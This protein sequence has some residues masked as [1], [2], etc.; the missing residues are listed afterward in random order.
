MDHQKHYETRARQVW[1]WHDHARDYICA[2]NRLVASYLPILL[3]K[4]VTPSLERS[5]SSFQP[6]MVL[7]AIAAENLLKALIIAQ[8]NDP[9]PMGT[10]DSSLKTHNLLGLA[11]R[12]G[13][14]LCSHES[15]LL[16]RMRDFVETG[17]YPVGKAAGVGKGSQWFAHP[18]DLQH[19]W[20][21]LQTLDD[22]VRAAR[23]PSLPEIDVKALCRPPRAETAAPQSV[24]IP[25]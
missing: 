10:L 9:V 25:G 1:R 13:L 8:G 5:H 12:A 2:A 23:K 17:K 20:N 7:F 21:V 18:D 15:D 11:G 4:G 14:K 24:R 19:T 6:I 3:A 16:V 22:A